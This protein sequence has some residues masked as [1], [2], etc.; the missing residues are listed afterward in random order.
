MHYYQMTI[1]EETESEYV[2][3]LKLWENT[4][5]KIWI[6]ISMDESDPCQLQGLAITKDDARVL[7]QELTR[8]LKGIEGE[9]ATGKQLT[10]TPDAAVPQK[11]KWT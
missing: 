10:L 6:Q 3:E 8:M 9:L 2:S 5:G 1:R 4:E 7:I 11:V